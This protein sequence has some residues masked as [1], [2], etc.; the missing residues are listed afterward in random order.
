MTL[1]GAEDSPPSKNHQ[2][3]RIQLSVCE[4]TFVSMEINRGELL[5]KYFDKSGLSRVVF[6]NSL[7]ISDNTL[8]N[9]CNDYYL[10]YEK[11]LMASPLLIHDFSEEI[12]LLK[13]LQ[14][15]RD[16]E[17]LIVIEP[18]EVYKKSMDS[19]LKTITDMLEE[20]GKQLQKLLKRK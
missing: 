12:P 15:N 10:G 4:N 20:H 7:G 13:H 6:C 9:W 8:T 2:N 18:V 16:E 11:L 14:Y 19:S 17:L 1:I 5:K 3:S